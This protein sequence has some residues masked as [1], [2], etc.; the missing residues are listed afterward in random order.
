MNK[1]DFGEE[2]YKPATVIADISNMNTRISISLPSSI[3][4]FISPNSVNRQAEIIPFTTTAPIHDTSELG[5]HV[6]GT[7]VSTTLLNHLNRFVT[8]LTL[9]AVP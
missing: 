9:N 5:D 6:A 4:K 8:T 1:Y 2:D 7:V 3:Q